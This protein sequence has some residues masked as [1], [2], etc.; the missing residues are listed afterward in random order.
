MVGE[1]GEQSACGVGRDAHSALPSSGCPSC[2]IRG[3]CLQKVVSH[4]GFD[5]H[6]DTWQVMLLAFL[7]ADGISHAIAAWADFTSA[8]DANL[9]LWGSMMT[10]A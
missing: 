7:K 1:S 2:V 10:G 4:G 9:A 3:G 8:V 6:R 5:S